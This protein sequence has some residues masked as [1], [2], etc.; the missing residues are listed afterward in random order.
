MWIS[1]HGLEGE[2]VGHVGLSGSSP[3]D[4]YKRKKEKPSFWVGVQPLNCG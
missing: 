3:F 4:E 1:P 2:I